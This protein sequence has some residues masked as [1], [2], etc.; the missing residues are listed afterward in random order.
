MNISEKIISY[1]ADIGL[2]PVGII[3]AEPLNNLK[4][5]LENQRQ[6]GLTPPFLHTSIQA[7]IDPQLTLPG[8]QSIICLA[9]PYL[10]NWRVEEADMGLENPK[11]HP[12]LQ[13]TGLNGK[14]EELCGEIARIACGQDYHRVFAAKAHQL[15]NFMNEASSSFFNYLVLSDT[16]PL[17]ERAFFEKAGAVRG[18]NTTIISSAYG[19]WIALGL[20]LVDFPLKNIPFEQTPSFRCLNCG[21]CLKACPT[22]ALHAPFQINPWRCLSFIT[23]NKGIIPP[24]YRELM[25]CRIY[26]C[27]TCQEVCPQ[28]QGQ[29]FSPIQEFNPSV[30]PPTLPLKSLAT[31]NKKDYYLTIG[32]TAAGWRGRQTLRRNAIVALGNS[33]QP[34]A[35]DLLNQLIQ[36]DPSPLIRMHTAWALG[37]LNTTE[38]RRILAARLSTENS[39][40]VNQEIRAALT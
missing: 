20:I 34:E 27:D 24:S 22:G 19:S 40:Q 1:A 30:L 35:A 4:P 17:L 23:Q 7:R 13:S 32:Q 15:I 8:C 39:K 36:T 21:R 25:G 18:A 29:P 6:D 16:N 2:S 11:D 28:N 37:Q 31:I 14:E 3:D 10:G 9:I 38:A 33:K 5:W 12:L 26:G